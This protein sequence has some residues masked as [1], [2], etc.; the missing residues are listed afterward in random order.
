MKVVLEQRARS[1]L[2]DRYLLPQESPDELFERVARVV[3]LSDRQDETE[4]RSV[5]CDL[6]FLPNSPTLMN[7][8]TDREQLI[9]CFVLPIK[10][11]LNDFYHT[12]KLTSDIHRSGGGTGFSFSSFKSTNDLLGGIKMIALVTELTQHF[13]KRRGANMGV[14]PI[15]HPAINDFIRIKTQDKNLG[16]FNL[17]VGITDEFMVRAAQE[18]KASLLF[19]QICQ[20]AWEVGDPGL[21]F[22]DEIQRKQPLSRLGVIEAT[23]P[24]GEVPLFPFEACVLGSINLSRILK[25]EK[26]EVIIDFTKLERVVKIAIRFLD[27]VIDK[28]SYPCEKIERQVKSTRKIGLGVMGFFEMLLKLG[29]AYDSEE[30]VK[31]AEKVMGFISEKAWEMSG[32]LAKERGVFPLWKESHFQEKN[33]FVRNA[34]VTAIA[35]T[36]SISVIAGTTPSIEAFLST[37]SLKRKWNIER[38]LDISVD[39]HLNIQ[40]AFQKFTDNAV[41]KTI[42]LPAFS[43][44]ERVKEVFWEAWKKKLKGV[45]VYRI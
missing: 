27:N 37:Q 7:C 22:L 41:S 38:A 17:S 15:E 5:L 16:S 13:G 11:E 29:I 2:K 36:G 14:L 6:E 39:A 42:N 19:D 18:K 4:F 28:S 34:T 21:I 33:H 40:Q 3:S 30:S 8:G 31:T 9:A 12:L 25:R 32:E 44:V 35:P 45:T 24:C 10:P 20:C 1:L 23:N 43:P 26:D